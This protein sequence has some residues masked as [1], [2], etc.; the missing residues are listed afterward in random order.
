MQTEGSPGKTVSAL[1]SRI[2][3]IFQDH[4]DNFWFGSNGSG[5]YRYDGQNLKQFTSEDGLASNQI[6]GIQEDKTGNVF[7]DTPGGVSK[8]DGTTFTTLQPVKPS[9]NKWQ[10]EPDDLWFNGNGD[11]QGAYR[12]DGKTLYHL[13]FDLKKLKVDRENPQS[14]LYGVFS[15]YKDSKGN[16]WLGTL[17]AGVCRYDG[18]VITWIREKDLFVLDDGRAPG[19]RAMIEDKDGHF[20]LS[21][22]LHR[23]K[24]YPRNLMTQK[25]DLVQ[26]DQLAGIKP[27]PGSDEMTFPYFMSAVL[28]ESENLWMT[29]YGNGAWKYDGEKLVNYQI[30]EEGANVLMISIYKDRQ[31]VLWLA[32]DNAGVYRFN[33]EAFEK[34]LP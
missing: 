22:T 28:D 1:D 15:T 19:V 5:V 3:V 26:Y 29:T 9:D 4:Q 31:D 6:R 30:E 32:T 12:Y 13:E 10:L 16:I 7:F 34:F 20:W 8:F 25:E 18:N 24:I 27:R 11:I 2:W 33:G 21:N 17:G 23:Y 14:S